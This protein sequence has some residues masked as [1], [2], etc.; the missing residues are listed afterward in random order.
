MSGALALIS[1]SGTPASAVRCAVARCSGV[2]GKLGVA[3]VAVA[4]TPI[5]A[6]P[7]ARPTAEQLRGAGGAG[8][9]RRLMKAGLVARGQM[10]RGVL[11]SSVA[12]SDLCVRGYFAPPRRSH[13]GSAK[14]FTLFG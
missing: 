5:T 9:D 8:S 13:R 3:A 12:R 7:S 1:L 2:I 6:R 11:G 4:A 10:A 14:I